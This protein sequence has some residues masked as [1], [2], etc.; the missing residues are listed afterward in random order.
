[1]FS[2]INGK[3]ADMFEP[4][5][6]GKARVTEIPKCEQLEDRVLLSLLGIGS[7]IEPPGTFYDATGSVDYNCEAQ[8]FDMTAVPLAIAGLSPDPILIQAPR[9][10]QLHIVVDNS[11]N[12]VGGVLGDDLRIEGE[13]TF[14]ETVYDGVLLTGEIV[15]FGY[16][17]ASGAGVDQYDFRFK[18]TGGAMAEFFENKDIGVVTSSANSSFVDSFAQDFTGAVRGWAAAIPLPTPASLSGFVYEDADSD[19]EIDANEYAIEGVTVTLSGIDDAGD[20]VNI[21]QTTDADGNY[22]FVDLRP[23]TYTVTETQP[24]GYADNIDTVGSLGG[25][26]GND[27]IS[28]IIVGAGQDG[29]NYNFG[30]Q[31]NHLAEGQTATIGFWQNKNGQSLLK[32]LNG[33]ENSTALGTWLATTFPNIYGAG[34]N[35]DL[36]GMTNKAVAEHYRARFKA[37]TKELRKLGITN[38]PKLE[39]QVMATAFA[40][41]VTSSTLAGNVAAGYGFLVTTNGVGAALFNIGSYGTELLGVADYTDVLIMDILY[42]TNDAVVDGD[43]YGLEGLLRS[44]ANEVYTAINE[45]GDLA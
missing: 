31:A 19:G 3:M 16:L 23:G 30:E 39:C 21:A 20:A 2:K 1:M 45:G 7:M 14:N 9:D 5:T 25:T 27:V 36:T 29:D 12:L 26:L 17:D 6:R 10:F 15:G 28:D 35:T 32:A 22:M 11:G 8:S 24:A 42:S 33:G 43:L 4:G 41:Y 18:L 40:V 37:K 13:F 38:A 44:L 34:S